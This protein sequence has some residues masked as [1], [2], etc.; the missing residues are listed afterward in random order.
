MLFVFLWST[1]FIGAKYGM[2]GAEPFTYLALRFFIACGV[3]AL[4]VPLFKSRWPGS[5]T[6]CFH[7]AV[8]GCLIHGVYLG[9]VFSAIYYGL[10]AGISAIIVGVHPLLTALI[11]SRWLG[12]TLNYINRLGLV[13]GF[14]GIVCVVGGDQILETNTHII[15]VWLC[16][17]SLLGISIGT[18]YQKRFCNDTDL[19][20]G[21]A[22]QY[23]AATVLL[24]IPALISETG[25][26]DWNAE[27]LGALL[28][29]VL[30][31]SLVAVLLLMLM[32]KH[33]EANRVASLFYLVPALTSLETWI[34]F[35]ETLSVVALYGIILCML[36]VYLARRQASVREPK[37]E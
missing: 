4:L 2:S 9:G 3:I 6:D 11:A 26:I 29:L 1:G 27:V 18:L 37:S 33:G 19:L 7:L 23:F 8:V 13:V 12:E 31:L 17:A 14:I 16:L 15:G 36:G 25:E 35:D 22:I 32:I 24:A 21:T 20:S 34:L 5:F 28:W 10:P 30:A